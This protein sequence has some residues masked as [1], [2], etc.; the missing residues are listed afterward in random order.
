[1]K[2]HLPRINSDR[3]KQMQE[4]YLKELKP[5]KES[6]MQFRN[7][8]SKV[9]YEPSD[10]YFLRI[11]QEQKNQYEMLKTVVLKSQADPEI[12]ILLQSEDAKTWSKE[13]AKDTLQD[14]QSELK[15][16]VH[17]LNNLKPI[18][19]AKQLKFQDLNTKHS[20][21]QINYRKQQSQYQKHT[22]KLTAT[23]SGLL[24]ECNRNDV[25][26]VFKNEKKKEGPN[27]ED[28]IIKDLSAS[29]S[30]I[31]QLKLVIQSQ[32]E[33][34]DQ[35]QKVAQQRTSTQKPGNNIYSLYSSKEF[36]PS[37]K[38]KKPIPIAAIGL[39]TTHTKFLKS[40]TTDPISKS[41]PDTSTLKK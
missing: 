32:K 34:I 19:M 2:Y 7:N 17:L 16:G 22:E 10:K 41:C 1:M 29:L 33:K 18:L 27:T 23:L 39:S 15:K 36:P 21:F 25:S 28:P 11:N 3:V 20:S 6:F 38:P 26:R 35:L 5:L 30:M 37:R 8:I 12:R 13:E 4:I 31:E 40:P 9:Y 24:A 14:E